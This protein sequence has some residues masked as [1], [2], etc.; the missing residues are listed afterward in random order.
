MSVYPAIR[1]SVTLITLSCSIFPLLR[2]NMASGKKGKKTKGKTLALND[3]LQETPGA[4]PIQPIRKSNVNWADE[5][6]EHV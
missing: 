2:W 6:D 3:F 1:Q 5:V 4:I